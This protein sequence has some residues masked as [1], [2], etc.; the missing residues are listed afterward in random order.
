M[1]DFIDALPPWPEQDFAAF[2]EVE[3]K[4]R[5]K[6]QQLVGRF[7][8]RNWLRIPHVTHH[9]EIDVTDLEARRRAWNGSNP[10]AKI[11]PVIP[12]IRAVALALRDFP[13]FASSLDPSGEQQIVKHYAHVGVAVDVPAG[14]LV[15]VIRDCDT[16][17][18]SLLASELAEIAEKAR[19][20]GLT[21][22]EMA[23]GCI[24]ISS[25]GHIGGTAFTPIVN[26][27][28]VAIV[29][30]TKLQERPVRADAGH[31]FAWRSFLPVSLSYDHRVINGADAARFVVALGRHLEA[32]RFA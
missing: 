19:T 31:G 9:D 7:L 28:E 18:L 12:V 25:L 23:G 27:P 17:D 21:M 29:G 14:L 4:P 30:L 15:P 26:A 8:G 13:Q 6:I 10:D 5:S 32:I 3:V 11:S 2:G 16:K 20:K 1:S 24:S 22:Q